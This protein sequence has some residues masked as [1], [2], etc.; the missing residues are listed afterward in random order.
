M[1]G[2]FNGRKRRQEKEQEK[3]VSLFYQQC[4]E[5]IEAYVENHPNPSYEDILRAAVNAKIFYELF[6]KVEGLKLK[7]RDFTEAYVMN[8]PAAIVQLEGIELEDAAHRVMKIFDDEIQALLNDQSTMILP[9][10]KSAY[11]M[12]I[13]IGFHEVNSS[14]R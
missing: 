14:I 13:L 1:F 9:S 4:V 11:L 7:L 12:S 8:A 6:R 5:G 10:V 2:F 3:R